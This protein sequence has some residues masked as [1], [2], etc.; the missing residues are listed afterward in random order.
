MHFAWQCLLVF[1]LAFSIDVTAA[2]HFKSL[3]GGQVAFAVVTVMAI[4]FL[5]YFQ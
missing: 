2:I 1:V 5:G 4:N 3:I